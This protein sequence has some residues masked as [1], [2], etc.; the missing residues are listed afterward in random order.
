V[1]PQGIARRHELSLNDSM[2]L[3]FLVFLL[4]VSVASSQQNPIKSLTLTWDANRISDNVTGY[5]VYE[6]VKSRSVLIGQSKMPRFVIPRKKGKHVYVVTAVS[7]KGE[8]A[9]SAPLQ[10]QN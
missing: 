9:P 2:K 8:S 3:G 7:A 10:V 5:C 6:L 4:S 1:Q